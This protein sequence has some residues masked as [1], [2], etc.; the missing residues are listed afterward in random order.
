MK[1]PLTYR[2]YGF[3]PYNISEIQKGIQYGHAVVEYSNAHAK[4]ADYKQWSTVDKTFIILNGGT[5]NNGSVKDDSKRF[6]IGSRDFYEV[7]DL[8]KNKMKKSPSDAKKILSTMGGMQNIAYR[9]SEIGIK[10]SIFQEPD[11]NHAVTGIAFLASN[12]VFDNTAESDKIME[13]I[14]DYET[15]ESIRLLS[16]YKSSNIV[17][18][19]G[20]VENLLLKRALKQ[21]KLA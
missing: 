5:T 13:A 10:F 18:T 21:Y 14:M 3:V 12:K 16:K 9:L 6:P 4:D 2:M 19:F 8:V 20:S 11:L 17:E 1:K 7:I 15:D